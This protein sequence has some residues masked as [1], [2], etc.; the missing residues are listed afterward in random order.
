[1]TRARPSTRLHTLF[2]VFA[3]AGVALSSGCARSVGPQLRAA[4]TAMDRA[5]SDG[6]GELEPQ[7]VRT[8]GQLLEVAEGQDDG[9]DQEAHYAYLAEREVRTA[10]ADARRDRLE[11]TAARDMELLARTRADVITI[12]ASVLFDTGSDV[13]TDAGRAHLGPIAEG[14]AQSDQ[15][16]VVTGFTDARGDE[17]AN[18][19]LSERRADAVGSFLV[20]HGVSEA[21]V[22]SEGL[23]EAYPVADNDTE[24]GR[25]Q[26]RRVEISLFDS[27][28]DGGDRA[29]A[30][31][32]R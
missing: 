3:L 2:L 28:A 18:R 15:L 16:A 19:G 26:N 20:A 9:S 10:M 32:V 12:A 5:R 31:A 11:Q 22:L 8:A 25:A 24:T 17:E 21:R 27:A 30:I 23:G 13:L 14:L 7:A 1:M 6:T 4:R 29:P